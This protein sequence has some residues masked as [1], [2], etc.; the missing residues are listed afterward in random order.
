MT[1][2]IWSNKHK[3]TEIITLYFFTLSR[4]NNI[5]TQEWRG[6]FPGIAGKVGNHGND[7]KFYGSHK[8][9]RSHQG[10]NSAESWCR[11]FLVLESRCRGFL[12]LEYRCRGTCASTASFSFS[13]NLLCHIINVNMWV[14]N[15]ANYFV[16]H[17][18]VF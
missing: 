3:F 5:H 8:I 11:G 9:I 14:V 12:V 4:R 10:Q 17:K 13:L 18:L 1:V 7:E 6:R 16:S 15:Y 2:C